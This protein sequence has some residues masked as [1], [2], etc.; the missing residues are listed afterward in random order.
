MQKSGLLLQTAFLLLYY[1]LNK[2]KKAEIFRFQ[3]SAGDE[4]FEPPLTV[5]ETVALPLN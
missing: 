2:N 4:G 3:L 5:L 1:F